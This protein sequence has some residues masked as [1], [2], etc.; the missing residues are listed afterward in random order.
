MNLAGKLLD[1]PRSGFGFLGGVGCAYLALELD[2]LIV[3][4]RHVPLGKP[5][6]A[7]RVASAG[8]CGF[9]KLAVLTAGSESR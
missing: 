5:R 1:G 4:V 7:S 3:A 9:W 6:L 2:L 8:A